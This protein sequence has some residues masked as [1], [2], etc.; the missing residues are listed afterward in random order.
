[1]SDGSGQGASSADQTPLDTFQ[2]GYD[3]GLEDGNP[4]GGGGGAVGPLSY[5]SGPAGLTFGDIS[6][7]ATKTINFS[8]TNGDFYAGR[9]VF[10]GVDS[11]YFQINSLTVNGLTLTPSTP[12][13]CTD[14][15]FAF[16]FDEPSGGGATASVTF[17][18]LFADTTE[19]T[20]IVDIYDIDGS[21]VDS[22]TATATVTD[23]IDQVVEEVGTLRLFM[24]AKDLVSVPSV[25]TNDYIIN[26]VSGGGPN[27][28]YVHNPGMS[29]VAGYGT[30][31]LAKMVK[32]AGSG[33]RLSYPANPGDTA[34][35]THVWVGSFEQ[36]SAE[37]QGSY[38]IHFSG[39]VGSTVPRLG[40]SATAIA[41][42]G[43]Y[44]LNTANVSN[45]VMSKNKVFAISEGQLVMVAL[46]MDYP[47]AQQTD[48]SVS[49]LVGGSWKDIG[50]STEA[51]WLGL[52][53]QMPRGGGDW[54]GDPDRYTET[55][56]HLCWDTHVSD[57]DL[58][59]IYNSL[60]AEAAS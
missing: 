20:M 19:Q 28:R 44:G 40:Y 16:S 38:A 7:G 33:A 5:D 27:L 60:V 24:S 2:E 46:R 53:G 54:W 26:Q 22:I 35:T 15:D 45:P 21:L 13:N 11:L 9:M 42:S 56:L 50:E 29:I 59:R 41:L 3:Q 1:M 12:H 39:G 31:Q 43:R 18:A 58:E 37:A 8:G 34:T 6:P 36:L 49:K 32:N 55:A 57:A 4:I 14:G 51:A 30:G 25:T 10:T 48:M 17:Q 52:Y 47:S 23:P